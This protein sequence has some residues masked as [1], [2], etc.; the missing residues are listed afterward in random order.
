MSVVFQICHFSIGTLLPIKCLK[1]FFHIYLSAVGWILYHNM[2]ETIWSST[3]TFEKESQKVINK[4]NIILHDH[5]PRK[6]ELEHFHDCVVCGSWTINI[7]TQTLCHQTHIAFTNFVKYWHVYL[8][9]QLYKSTFL[10]FNEVLG[11]SLPFN[12]V[13]F[14]IFEKNWTKYFLFDLFLMVIF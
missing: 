11:S 3:T 14:T 1:H 8:L 9:L 7:D 10:L 2:T 5:F 4:K 13:L 6:L 12:E